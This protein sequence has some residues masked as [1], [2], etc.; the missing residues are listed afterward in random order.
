[1]PHLPA[2]SP[3]AMNAPNSM[4]ICPPMG[5]LL[6]M[7]PHA[8]SHALP[9]DSLANLKASRWRSSL[10]ANAHVRKKRIHRLV[11][12]AHATPVRPNAG[13][14]IPA[15]DA[16]SM[17]TRLSAAFVA[18]AIMIA[19]TSGAKTLVPMRLRHIAW[20]RSTGRM[21]HASMWQYCAAAAASA[22]G[23]PQSA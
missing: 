5:K 23:C 1:M 20:K 16:P 11:A 21:P 17:R 19:E 9:I 2:M 18:L 7:I 3:M 12:V 8:R 14:V 15:T 4:S 22:T 10:A 13:I 6:L